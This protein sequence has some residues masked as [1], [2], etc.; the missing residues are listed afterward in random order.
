MRYFLFILLVSAFPMSAMA[1]EDGTPVSAAET[2][3]A[4]EQVSAEQLQ[5][6]KKMHDIWPIRSRIETAIDMVAQNAPPAKQ[7]ELKARMR[8]AIQ[9]D[10]VEEESIR[11]MAATFTAQ[12]LQAMINFYGSDTGRS[13]SAKTQD[14]EAVMRPVIVKM[15]DKAMLD[16][17]TGM[18]P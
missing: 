11:A 16:L 18:T 14:Y 7:A 15:L 1:Q 12:E 10:Q 2:L 4:E 6:A 9:F 17:K 13:I 8:R 3:P 5:L